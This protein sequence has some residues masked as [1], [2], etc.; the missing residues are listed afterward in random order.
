LVAELGDALDTRLIV[1]STPVMTNAGRHAGRPLA[2]C[3]VPPADLHGGLAAVKEMVD[4]YHEA[5]M[6]TGFCL[7]DLDH[8][9]GTLHYLNDVAV[10]GA[11]SGREDR[12]VGNMA[13]LLAS[14]PAA[15][16]F[17]ACKDGADRRRLQGHYRV[18]RRIAHDPAQGPVTPRSP[19][20]RSDQEYVF[21]TKHDRYPVAAHLI[22]TGPTATSCSCAAP[23][24]DGPTANSP[25][26]PTT[27][28]A[29]RPPP[30]PSFARSRK[31]SASPRP[32]SSP[33]G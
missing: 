13:V 31:N 17:A 14:H 30:N 7:D 8:P 10:A 11:A 9:V 2:A 33:P 32:P 15:A 1:F 25:C 24:P 21:D 4:S 3:S 18:P 5:A 23:A 6:G 29:A 19:M 28:T 22:L 16:E 12:P 26:P 27:S 20:P